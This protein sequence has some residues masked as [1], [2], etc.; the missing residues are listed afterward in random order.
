MS[1][2]GVSARE[3]ELLE[4]VR[5]RGILVFNPIETSNILGEPRENTYRIL[6]RMVK[7]GLLVRLEKGRYISSQELEERD[8]YE[9]ACYIVEPSYLS[10]WSGLHHY[11]YTTQVPR[12]ICLMV[13]TPRSSLIVQNQPIRFVKTKHFFGYKKE[14]R[15]VIAETE[16]LFLD[17]LLFPEYAGGLGEILDALASA[18]LDSGKIVDY[19]LKIGNRSLNSRL[20]HLLQTTGKDFDSKRLKEHIS[21]NYVLLVPS[22][23]Y[24]GKRIKE[25][26]IIDNMG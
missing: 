3:R 19:A 25:W 23:K 10:L 21:K 20:G 26:N 15:C 8:I 12:D 18:E 14:G 17:C 9:M 5:K 6:S 7:K 4:E 13:A 24:R 16:K 2:A 22:A 1:Y 11:G